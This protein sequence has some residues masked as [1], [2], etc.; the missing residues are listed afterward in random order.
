MKCFIVYYALL[1]VLLNLSPFLLVIKL[2]V[3]SWLNSFSQSHTSS[4]DG[5]WCWLGSPVPSACGM[6]GTSLSL[7]PTWEPRKPVMVC[8]CSAQSCCLVKFDIYSFQV[9]IFFLSLGGIKVQC[10]LITKKNVLFR[11]LRYK[12][13]EELG[14]VK[15]FPDNPSH[16]YKF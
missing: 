14:K 2:R 13:R 5:A 7:L 4:E 6:R 8:F 15:E 10:V 16:T 1:Y 9:W 12:K 11:V 3:R